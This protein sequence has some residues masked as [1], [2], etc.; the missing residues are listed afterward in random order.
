MSPDQDSK[1]G[2]DEPQR[3]QEVPRP[4][5]LVDQAAV[6]EGAAPSAPPSN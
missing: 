4:D 6:V 3:L 5:H 1:H 2:T